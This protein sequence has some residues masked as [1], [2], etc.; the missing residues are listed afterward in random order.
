VLI[1]EL[2]HRDSKLAKPRSM[3]LMTALAAFFLP[4]R[5]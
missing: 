1:S 5:A 3:V 2:N 4:G